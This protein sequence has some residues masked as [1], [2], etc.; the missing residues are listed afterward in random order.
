MGDLKTF[1]SV[2]SVFLEPRLDVDFFFS[3]HRTA[4]LA[5]L[6]N[7]LSSSSSSSA[8]SFAVALAEDSF[9]HF[10]RS[11][12]SSRLFSSPSFV[13]TRADSASSSLS[14]LWSSSVSSETFFTLNQSN[15]LFPFDNLLSISPYQYSSIGTAWPWPGPSAARR[16]P[17][18]PLG[19]A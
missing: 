10:S 6:K 15:Q 19:R 14:R 13:A 9:S 5:M 3:R 8:K 2:F 1:A 4:L 16:P 11:S 17:E 12:L 7:W 18:R